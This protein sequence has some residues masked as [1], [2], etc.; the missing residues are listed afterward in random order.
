MSRMD[1][2]MSQIDHELM[3]RCREGDFGALAE[4]VDRWDGRVARVL[5]R[6]VASPS[7]VEDLRQEVFLKVFRARNRYRARGAFSTWL[8][9]IVLN[10][11]RDAARRRRP[12]PLGD[13]EPRATDEPAEQ[14]AEQREVR[15]QV[16]AALE[17]LPEMLREPLVLKHY[18]ELTFAQIAEVTGL[19]ASTVKSRVGAALVRLRRALE[20]QGISHEELNR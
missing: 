17:T 19:P 11:A 5:A 2:R 8:Y 18:S 4:L 6:L 16:A 9:R 3:R 20:R 1:R 14:L 13:H 15:R 7:E 10:V 12:E